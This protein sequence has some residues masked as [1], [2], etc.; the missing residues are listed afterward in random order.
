MWSLPV[1][2][3]NIPSI[4]SSAFICRGTECSSNPSKLHRN[5]SA[6]A[7]M[8]NLNM[9]NLVSQSSSANP[10]SFG[11]FYFQRVYDLQQS[12]LLL[13]MNKTFQLLIGVIDLIE[14]FFKYVVIA[15][16]HIIHMGGGEKQ[17]YS[18]S[19][20]LPDSKNVSESCHIDLHIFVSKLTQIEIRKNCLLSLRKLLVFYF[21]FLCPTNQE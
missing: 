1:W 18:Y 21:Y 13:C 10:G 20:L 19:A 6:A 4:L 2:L 5:A 7:N 9:N 14:Y 8:N 12:Y 3:F 11:V 15:I 16:P 17:H